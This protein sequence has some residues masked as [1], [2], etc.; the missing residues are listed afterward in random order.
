M[1]AVDRRDRGNIAVSRV[2]D[3]KAAGHTVS[4]L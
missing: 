4:L 1:M 2:S 3:D